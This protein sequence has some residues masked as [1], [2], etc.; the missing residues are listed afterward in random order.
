MRVVDVP[1]HR[2]GDEDHHGPQTHHRS[3]SQRDPRA[4]RAVAGRV[5][6]RDRRGG[7]RPG[8]RRPDAGLPALRPRP[9]RRARGR[10]AGRRV[11]R[12]GGHVGV[13]RRH[14]HGLRLDV[15]VVVLRRRV[16]PRRGAGR[17][18]RART[19]ATGPT[20][21]TCSTTRASSAPTSA[22]RFGSSTT[23]AEGVPLTIRLTV[24]DAVDR[25]RR[26]R[27]PAVYLWHCDRDGNYSLYAP[28]LENENYLR[29]VQAADADGTVEFTSIYPA[30]LRRPLAA[31]PLRGLR[32]TSPTR[33]RPARS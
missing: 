16:G 19:R 27:A 32:R 23:T 10:R 25:A 24:R 21:S 22:R 14:H 33:R 17:D 15:V 2:T 28:G 13:G 5:G 12:Y 31:H 8:L 26:R 18:R 6:P 20:A 4:R 29:G 3:P 11:R 1:P 9:L 30:A 7:P